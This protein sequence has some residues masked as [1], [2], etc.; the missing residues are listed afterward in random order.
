MEQ[1]HVIISQQDQVE[2]FSNRL[3]GITI[4]SISFDGDESIVCFG[5]EY[6]E[7]IIKAIRSAKRVALDKKNG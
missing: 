6:A 1:E 7:R 5:T 4:K 3:D 2:V